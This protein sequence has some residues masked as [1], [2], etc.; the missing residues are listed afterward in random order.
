MK[1]LLKI[2]DYYLISRQNIL[3]SNIFYKCLKD[4]ESKNTFL[5]TGKEK[6]C[7]IFA[8]EYSYFTRVI[9]H[10]HTGSYL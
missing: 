1:L 5:S 2:R 6:Y 4:P 10:A 7:W 8:G 3:Q 9:R